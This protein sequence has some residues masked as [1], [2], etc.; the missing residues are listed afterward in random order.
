VNVGDDIQLADYYSSNGYW[1]SIANDVSTSTE[2]I[3]YVAASSLDSYTSLSYAQVTFEGY[4]LTSSSQ[5]PTTPLYQDGIS[6]YSGT[7]QINININSWG[8]LAE[9]TSSSGLSLTV[10]MNT[11]PNEEWS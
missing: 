1:Y 11:T 3:Y 9:P 4:Q 6:I 2:A 8:Q 10:S 5:F 7:S